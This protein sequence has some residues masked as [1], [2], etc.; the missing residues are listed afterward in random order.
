[1]I[2]PTT[3]YYRDP[4]E[5]QT[6]LASTDK[7]SNF[8][9]GYY[10][11]DPSEIP[12]FMGA[13]GGKKGTPEYDNCKFVMMGDNIFAALYLQI[14]QL[15]AKAN[16]FK[17]TAMQKLKE[18]IHFHAT[19][20]NQDLSFRL[21]A[22]STAMKFRDKKKVTPTFH[23]AGLVVPY[24]KETQLGYREI[25][26]TTANL[27]KIFARVVDAHKDGDEESKNKAL[28]VLQELITNVQFANDEGDPGM[29][30]EL[31]LD[32]LLHGGDC[33]NSTARHLLSVAYGLLNRDAFAKI[34]NAHM[35]RR[36][37]GVACFKAQ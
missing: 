6:I 28:D 16:P 10:R 4:P 9:V 18:S 22:K 19:M 24:N 20:K 13:I 32:A 31:G 36:K 21:E 11:D 30:L 29:G 8:H 12:V 5:F 25:P 3:R 23:G 14:A 34:A 2:A 1:L 35:N 7:E 37:E 27:K 26:E 15:V 17:M 33:L